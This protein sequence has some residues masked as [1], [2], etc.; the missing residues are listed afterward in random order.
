M[1]E[2][3]HLF[4]LRGLALASIPLVAPGMVMSAK[5]ERNGKAELNNTLQS[6]Q[7]ANQ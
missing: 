2:T 1:F 4:K 5:C 3:F 7:G 6:R